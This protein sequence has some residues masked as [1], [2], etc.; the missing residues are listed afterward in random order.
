MAAKRRRHF[1]CKQR[2]C[3]VSNW[4]DGEIGPLHG[5]KGR[6]GIET[7]FV[8]GLL[9]L[10]HIYGLSDERACERLVHDPFGC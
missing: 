9:L 4:L 10:K 6:P 3:R 1:I 5:D 7:R 2:F 8:L